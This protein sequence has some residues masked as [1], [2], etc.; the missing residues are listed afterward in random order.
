MSYLDPNL[1]FVDLE[2]VRV[3]VLHQAPVRRLGL[4]PGRHGAPGGQAGERVVLERLA[5]YL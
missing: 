5:G 2:R 1:L 3:L 4:N